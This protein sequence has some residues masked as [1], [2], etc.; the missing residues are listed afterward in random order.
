MGF[1]LLLVGFI[2]AGLEGI[3][4]AVVTVILILFISPNLSPSF[5]LSLYGGRL[6]SAEN[7]PGLYQI[8]QELASRANLPAAPSLYYLP[9]HIMNAFSVGRRANSAIGISDALLNALTVRELIG[10]LAH[11]ISHIQHND[12]RVMTY[13]DIISWI[14]S[15]L[16]LVGF[17]V[18]FFSLPLFFL[19]L[20]TISWLG[21]GVLIVAPTFMSFLQQTLSRIRE[22]DAD[23]QAALLTGDPEGLAMALNKLEAYES[24][25][26]KI[27]FGSGRSVSIPSVLRTHPDTEERIKRLLQLK[28]PSKHALNYA[29]HD[30]FAIPVH[31][32]KSIRNPR[33]HLGGFWY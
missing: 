12:V 4:W 8:A 21:L 26:F 3:I 25:L 19:G 18:I 15:T 17:F 23:H 9:S 29:N 7:A 2:L 27:L 16:S 6:L 24:S 14:T 28:E 31:Y 33:W 22:F 11:E 1:I 20:V 5:I 30:R 10:V 32:Q 13:A